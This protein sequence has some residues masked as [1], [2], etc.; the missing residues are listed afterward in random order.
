MD[1][2]WIIL[3]LA[4]AAA[5]GLIP[6]SI[7]RRKGRSFVAWWIFGAITWIIAMVAVLLV[8]DRRDAA[9]AQP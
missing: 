5:L 7:A 4:V 9:P 8:S 1:A 6:A 3:A 2:V